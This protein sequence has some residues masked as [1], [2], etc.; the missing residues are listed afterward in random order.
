MS[1][2]NTFIYVFIQV[3]ICTIDLKP[4]FEYE[5]VPK[6]SQHAFLKAKVKNE[7]RY[8]LLAGPA[9]VFL[10][11]AFV[12]KT[13]LNNVSPQEEFSCSLGNSINC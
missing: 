9:N 12:T 7:S 6:L 10:D 4:T 8:P 1:R 3:S 13:S 5:T 2:L 11:Q